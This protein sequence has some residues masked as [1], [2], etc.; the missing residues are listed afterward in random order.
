MFEV[1]Q[2]PSAIPLAHF[3]KCYHR[4]CLTLNG[5]GFPASGKVNLKANDHE[6]WCFHTMSKTLPGNNK[7]FDDVMTMMFL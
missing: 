7:I 2:C 1:A 3:S 6:I 4:K 5:P